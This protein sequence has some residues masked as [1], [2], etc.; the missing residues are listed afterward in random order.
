MGKA[1]VYERLERLHGYVRLTPR[2]RL[3][4]NSAGHECDGEYDYGGESLSLSS[5]PLSLL[6]PE[7]LCSSDSSK[8]VKLM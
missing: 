8:A 5:S 6:P 4:D 1:V 7:A 2:V 3:N